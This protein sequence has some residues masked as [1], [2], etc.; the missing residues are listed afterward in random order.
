MISVNIFLTFQT[1]LSNIQARPFTFFALST[2]LF[3][4]S[5]SWHSFWFRGA[6]GHIQAHV[7]NCRVPMNYQEQ[8]IHVGI[9]SR[10]YTVSYPRRPRH[11]LFC[12]Y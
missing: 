4:R 10:H 5:A 3:S 9:Q 12:N 2:G 8:N 11:E 1:F 7:L 6:R